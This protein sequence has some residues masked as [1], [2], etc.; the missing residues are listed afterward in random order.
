MQINDDNQPTFGRFNNETLTIDLGM[1]NRHPIDILRTLA[2]ELVHFR[3]YLKGQLNPNSG[4]T[5]NP[6]ENEAHEIAG[7]IM[8]HFN[9]AHRHYFNS[10]PLEI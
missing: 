3:Q 9:K 10:K 8:R 6:E 7:V 5:G 1:A 2:H 4:E